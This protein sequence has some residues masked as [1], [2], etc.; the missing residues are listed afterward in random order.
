[1]IAW[2]AALLLAAQGPA[3]LAGSYHTQQM[4]VGAALELRADGTFLYMLDYGAVSEASEG[5]WTADKGIVHLD[6]DPL[7]KEL[8][9]QIERSDAAFSDEK[10]AVDKG[11]LVMQRHETIFTF[12]RDEP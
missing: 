2:V 3:S 4:E 8:M 12:Y 1:M 7:A 5:H 9:I 10:L 11:S 6:S